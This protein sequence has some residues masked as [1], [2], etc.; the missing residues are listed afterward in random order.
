LLLDSLESDSELCFSPSETDSQIYGFL[1]AEPCR[2]C[3]A[4]FRSLL[5]LAF[6]V[7][8]WGT[9]LGLATT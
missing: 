8:F 6:L 7:S 2:S 4:S 5:F 3:D 1:S 9:A